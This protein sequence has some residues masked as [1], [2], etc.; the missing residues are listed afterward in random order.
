MKK[1]VGIGEAIEDIRAGRMVILVDDEDRENEGDLV[2]A[3]TAATP[4][5]LN[6]M[7]REARG[8]ACLALGA[9]KVDSLRL[10][11]MT[12]NNRAPLG[13]AF[14]LSV[15]AR[16]GITTGASATDRAHTIATIMADGCSMGDLSI[17]GHTHPLRA[18]PGG[19]LVRAGQ[20]EGSVD[21]ARLAG[22]RE[23]AV[24]CEIMGD[25]GEMMRLDAL[26]EFGHQHHI[27]VCTVADLI[28]YRMETESLVSPVA[29]VE[30]PT[31]FGM[32]RCIAFENE[33]DTRVHVAMVM[34]RPTPDVPTLVRVHRAD[35]VADVFGFTGDG[36]TNRLRWSMERIAQEGT[37]VVLYLRT[38]TDGSMTVDTFRSWLS[39]RRSKGPEVPVA[40]Q[41]MDFRE[42]GLGAQILS[43][44][45]CGKLRVITN[46]PRIPD[47]SVRGFGLSIVDRVPIQ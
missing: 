12:A 5:I 21:L 13:T 28:A 26:L 22:L 24:I 8:L 4:E 2:V 42:F 32:F 18:R 47:N 33:L 29:E 40:P 25:D 44:V 31:D 10:P 36:T 46:A 11:P 35:L 7:F 15:N 34:G 39:R 23:G 16:E 6:F 41:K 45:G 27:K 17:P 9:E 1:L 3:A 19:V 30:L 43:H 38:G 20:T 37:G 14:T